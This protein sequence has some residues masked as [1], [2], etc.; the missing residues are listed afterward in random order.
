MAEHGIV[1]DGRLGIAFAAMNHTMSNRD[2]L[3]AGVGRH[4]PFQQR[5]KS[6]VVADVFTDDGLIGDFL[7]GLVLGDQF[8]GVGANAVNLAG[9]FSVRRNRMGKRE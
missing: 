7:S 1:D 9:D 4:E 6:L 2:D 8:G 3:P 5:I